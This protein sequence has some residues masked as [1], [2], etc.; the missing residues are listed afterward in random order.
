[1]HQRKCLIF[2]GDKTLSAGE[3][4]DF[5]A[6]ECAA[7]PG[8]GIFLF[9]FAF[10]QL[11]DQCF[12]GGAVIFFCS[13]H[14]L[15]PGDGTDQFGI[16]FQ[17]LQRLVFHE[18]AGDESAKT[19]VAAENIPEAP[20][21]ADGDPVQFVLCHRFPF[22]RV[23]DRPDA[24]DRLFRMFRSGDGKDG[25]KGTFLCIKPAGDHFICDLLFCNQFPHE[26]GAFR[27]GKDL[28]KDFLHD[29][30]FLSPVGFFVG[31]RDP[32]Q[33][34]VVVCLFKACGGLDGFCGQHGFIQSAQTP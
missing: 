31:E 12:A 21:D 5:R 22:Q 34:V 20:F 18:P 14:D 8:Y 25:G 32:A 15:L 4:F 29:L 13:L 24:L 33:R 27:A 30:V 6:A 28:G 1:M 2:N 26:P 11:K 16:V 3:R 7:A 17:F 9:P 10:R 19:P 23:Q